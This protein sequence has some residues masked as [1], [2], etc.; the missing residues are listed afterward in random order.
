[1]FL[2]P[3]TQTSDSL[4]DQPKLTRA[5]TLDQILC[6]FNFVGQCQ[7]VF[8]M[9]DQLAA[10]FGVLYHLRN[11]RSGRIGRELDGIDY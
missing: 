2:V 9:P 3:K 8:E 7:S 1:M 11:P 5:C 10:F 4:A 6:I